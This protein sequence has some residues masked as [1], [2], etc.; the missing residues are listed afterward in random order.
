MWRVVVGDPGWGTTQ[1]HPSHGRVALQK[2]EKAI[3]A[4]LQRAR[5]NS[6]EGLVPRWVPER[7]FSR[8]KDSKAFRQMVSSFGGG[9]GHRAPHRGGIGC[10][11]PF[12]SH[13]WA[14]PA[15]P[16]ALACFLLPA[17]AHGL[18]EPLGLPILGSP[19]GIPS[20]ITSP[21]GPPRCPRP[22]LPQ[23]SGISPIITSLWQ[24]PSVPPVL[25]GS[26]GSPLS[27]LALGPLGGPLSSLVSDPPLHP[28][29]A[30]P[31]HPCQAWGTLGDPPPS[32][33]PLGLCPASLVALVTLGDVPCPCHL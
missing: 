3:L 31:P 33:L 15:L 6:T 8:T 9:S 26:W 25:T 30:T 23:P 16:A 12:R 4:K 32:W 27:S 13:C 21:W 2:E 19:L 18:G 20:T 24:S 17:A 1:G 11:P 5:A 14:S 28:T 29:L 10:S 7:S 22:P